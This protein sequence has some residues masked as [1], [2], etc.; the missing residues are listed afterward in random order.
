MTSD[1][2]PPYLP[3]DKNQESNITGRMDVPSLNG[4]PRRP[5]SIAD[6]DLDTIQWLSDDLKEGFALFDA[7]DRLVAANPEYLRLHDAV[8]DILA[9]GLTFEAMIRAMH[10]R[11]AVHD[12]AGSEEDF[13]ANRLR[14][15]RNPVGPVLRRLADGRAFIIKET[16]LDDGS[17]ICRENDVTELVAAKEALHESEERFK[18]LAEIAS[19]W[20]W[21]TNAEHRFTAITM[22]QPLLAG[23]LQ[24]VIGRTRW[25]VV[26]AD[27][28]NDPHWA[29]HKADLDAYRPFKDF[30][31]SFVPP[32]G[33]S[34]HFRVS[35]SAVFNKAGLAIG[36]RTMPKDDGGRRHFKVSG[37]P[38]FDRTGRFAGYRGTSREVTNEILTE[39][40][41]S[42][43]HQRLLDAIEAMP[44]SLILCDAEDRIVLCNS[45]TYTRLP[46]CKT[47]LE[48]GMKF[49]DLLRDLAFTGAV[50]G[51]RGREEDWIREC[52]HRHRT[53]AGRREYRLAD[54]RWVAVTERKTADGGTV[55]IRAD[56]TE[57]KHKELER[58]A[59]LTQAREEIRAKSTFIAHF[60]H[61][62][63][64]PIDLIRRLAANLAG[65]P[66]RER[67]AKGQKDAAGSIDQT[68][69]QTLRLIDDVLDVSR[70]QVR[71]YQ[72][73]PQRIDVAELLRECCS[74]A[75]MGSSDR[76]GIAIECAPELG[77]VHAD[78]A[79]MRRLL[80]SIVENACRVEP[81]SS[82]VTV[83]A[84]ATAERIE[85]G[86]HDNGAVPSKADF[87]MLMYP[88]DHAAAEP[89]APRARPFG[90][91]LAI[92]SALAGEIGGLLSVTAPPEGGTRVVLRLPRAE[93]GQGDP[94]SGN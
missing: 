6:L 7:D 83:T 72:V 36:Y 13:V 87:D 70:I 47:L 22:S 30:H 81:E 23:S 65:P 68:A 41:A 15:H 32:T 46:W 93:A 71:K 12:A 24:G 31:Y 82:Y 78:E 51:A 21:E 61:E 63:R 66:E 34:Q 17:V 92:A 59:A 27:P 55:V 29:Q 3:V 73:K 91:G 48:P 2:P 90:F 64:G 52:L 10:A 86:V 53:A 8:R 56:I 44:E 58:E 16:R 9:P 35:G 60:T 5:A 14:Q 80:V 19:D 28:M 50:S 67:L 69:E 40:R 1:Q 57:D 26:G 77:F 74:E 45:A 25:E 37:I 76:P 11:G 84:S 94:P 42:V 43:A 38:V 49:E 54:G 88:F 62:L 89:A 33:M 20:F 85:I 79:A 39:R 18:A 4:P 75:C